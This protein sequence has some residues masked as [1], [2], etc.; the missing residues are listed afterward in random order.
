L[1]QN[2]LLE[3][4]RDIVRR[5]LEAGSTG[6]ECRIGEGDEFAAGVRRRMGGTA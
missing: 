1:S 5:A 4:A 2:H 3:L 6:T